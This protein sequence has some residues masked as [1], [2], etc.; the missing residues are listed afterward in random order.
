MGLLSAIHDQSHGR[1]T[2]PGELLFLDGRNS[3]SF[4][5]EIGSRLM[6]VITMRRCG[7]MGDSGFCWFQS[8]CFLLSVFEGVMFTKWLWSL[9]HTAQEGSSQIL[10]WRGGVPQWLWV[11]E[12]THICIGIFEQ[13]WDWHPWLGG[14]KW[15]NRLIG[16][17]SQ[18]A[19]HVADV[20]IAFSLLMFCCF[21]FVPW[22]RR[23]VKQSSVVCH[24][25]S[26]C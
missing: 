2:D 21:C 8:N 16:D 17:C 1:Y 20:K 5:R 3:Q 4:R 25:L 15:L 18:V 10:I 12:S 24:L 26:C 19:R 6:C 23:K 13:R 22:N 14:R 9:K 7:I 11:T